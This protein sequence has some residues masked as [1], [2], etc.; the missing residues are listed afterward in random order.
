MGRMANG[1]AVPAIPGCRSSSAIG[2]DPDRTLDCTE[3][4][5]AIVKDGER[6]LAF[7]SKRS[8]IVTIE[9]EL[10]TQTLVT[11]AY[12]RTDL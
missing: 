6:L 9:W 2:P 1:S 7:R 12:Q 4:E 11:K 10:K 8:A 5:S 3:A